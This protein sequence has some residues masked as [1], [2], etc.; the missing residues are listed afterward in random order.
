MLHTPI[1]PPL[2][3]TITSLVSTLNFR[4]LLQ[5]TP[6]KYQIIPYI[7]IHVFSNLLIYILFAL[8]YTYFNL[9]I[10]FVRLHSSFSCNLIPISQYLLPCSHLSF[11]QNF[12]HI[13]LAHILWDIS[14]H[15]HWAIHFSG[16]V[17]HCPFH[18]LTHLFNISVFIPFYFLTLKTCSISFYEL[19]FPHF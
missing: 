17:N 18:L 2:N 7:L 15:P 16:A 1:T 14:P 8:I 13:I 10:F 5:H 12:Y 19:V 11:C 3:N 4:P 9:S 6:S